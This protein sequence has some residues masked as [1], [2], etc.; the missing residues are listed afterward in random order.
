[1]ENILEVL[2]LSKSYQSFKLE[3]ISFSLPRGNIMG[4]IGKNGAGKTTIINIILDI[5][6]RDSGIINVFGKQKLKKQDYESIGMVFDD[7]SL[8]EYVSV[9]EINNIFKNIYVNWD[10]EKYFDLIS[11]LEVPWN[12]K[13]KEMSK[14]NRIKSNLAVALSHKPQL[15]ILDEITGALD[16]VMRSE[17]L[18]IFLEFI[19]DD[20]RSILFSS[21]IIS[22]IEK[23]AD[24]ITYIDD[25]KVLFSKEKDDLVY[26]Y[27][28]AKCKKT[29]YELLDKAG[30][31][32]CLYE[33][34]MIEFVVEK[35]KIQNEYM[36]GVL[37]ENASIEDIMIILAKGIVL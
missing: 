10:E 3:N 8:P 4:L 12:T 13:I 21:H 9:K 32:A 16:P 19:Q 22:D 31:I 25:G 29:K 11:R 34:N 35:D 5:I 24:Y 15:L 33:N 2:N 6:K 27:K 20:S 18:K 30:I 17:I 36:E 14:G 28:I 26:N 7:N 1:M 37:I 23:I